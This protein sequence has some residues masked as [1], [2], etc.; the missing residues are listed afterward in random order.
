[1]EYFDVLDEKGKKTGMIKPRNEVHRDGDWHR[2][3]HVWIFN[4]NGD[5][6]LQRR[7]Q[8]KDSNPG[9]L[10]LSCGG[11]L[12]AGDDSITG[13]IRELKEELGIDVISSE[14][15]Y[16]TT[17]QKR[18]KYSDTHINSEFA[19]VY[20]LNTTKTINDLKFQEE[21]ITEIM[22]V[23]YE[24]FKQMVKNKQPDLLLHSEE[25][26]ILFDICDKNK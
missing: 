13:A 12:S 24:K 8:T 23:P 15:K 11:H 19:D 5:I 14:L 18:T 9:K 20:F 10:D 17:I 6:L 21:E 4:E 1:M 25:Y 2:T 7:S 26:E 22:F 3:I 16:I